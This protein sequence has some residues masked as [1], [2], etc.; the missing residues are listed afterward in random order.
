M[1][2]FRERWPHTHT[3][4]RET[5]HKPGRERI[6]MPEEE[7]YVEEVEVVPPTGQVEARQDGA[8]PM[9]EA[10]CQHPQERNRG[11]GR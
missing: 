4:A 11:M 8:P 7:G 1:G 9:H 3:H 2:W 5:K 10:I 6:H